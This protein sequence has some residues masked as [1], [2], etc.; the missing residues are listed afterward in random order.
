VVK[1]TSNA[2][3]QEVKAIPSV[4]KILNSPVLDSC[5]N[6]F[7]QHHI[8]R[9][10]R[11]V[12]ALIR[13]LLLDEALT[14]CPLLDEMAGD[15]VEILN[16]DMS[17]GMRRVINLSGTCIHT[18]LGRA[19]MPEEVV[20]Q[21]ADA[22]RWPSTLEYDLETGS[23]GN[24][25][26]VVSRLLSDLTGA[27]A[28]LVVNNNAAAVFLILNTF[29]R[30]REVIISRGELV[31]I[32]GAFRLPDIIES[33]GAVMREIGT[34]NRTR[35][36][37]YERAINSAT[38]LLLK[39]HP[40]NYRIDGFTEKVEGKDLS[41]LAARHDL[42]A[43]ED[44]GSGALFNYSKFGIPGEPPVSEVITGGLDLVSFSGDKLLGGP[45][46]GIIVG[47]RKLV[48]TLAS[49]PITRC[50]RPCKLTLAGLEGI[51]KLHYSESAFIDRVPLLKLL[52][53]SIE[54]VK[55]CAERIVAEIQQ[56]LISLLGDDLR[57]GIHESTTEIGSG[58]LP[59][60][61]V[62]TWTIGISSASCS[63]E[64]LAL[65]FRNLRIPVIGRVAR[66]VF[67]LDV[68][69]ADEESADLIGKIVSE[70]L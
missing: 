41:N 26:R 3:Y 52:T 8:V 51:L 36:E 60:E 35:L 33:S 13:N 64:E 32:G 31:E 56:P 10:I 12:T 19:C 11:K 23:R 18:N 58:A 6:K 34:T 66:E 57:I 53:R 59:C 7:D 16:T 1:V 21:I 9:A 5:R 37:D 49:N 20:Q 22:A 14:E 44:L 48:E 2:K 45:Q 24:R 27:E 29:A 70:K 28:G 43:F 40:S 15:A 61:G 54:E 68:R 67:H 63:V 47:K 50:L 42:I 17:L 39:V 46:A 55:S 38:A 30:S 69:M 62:S 4:E 25:H 65:F